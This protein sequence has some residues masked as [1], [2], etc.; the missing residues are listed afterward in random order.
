[1]SGGSW[2][3]AAWRYLLKLTY[4]H[5]LVSPGM[6]ATVHTFFFRSVLIIDDFPVFGPPISPTDICFLSE[7]R[8]ENCRRSC[9]REPLPNE[10]VILAWKAKVGCS[11][12]RWRTHAAYGKLSATLVSSTGN[13]KVICVC[14]N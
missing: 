2:S 3:G 9:I 4:C 5:T 1:M 7:C 11:F 12:D 6:G 14:H 13:R 10:F 8:L